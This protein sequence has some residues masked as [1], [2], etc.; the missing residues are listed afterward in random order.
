MWGERRDRKR[1]KKK[2]RRGEENRGKE[3]REERRA[4]DR[5]REGRE[6]EG[7]RG[8]KR[9]KSRGVDGGWRTGEPIPF[10]NI[11]NTYTIYLYKPFTCALTYIHTK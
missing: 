5:R 7:R 10:F 1:G 11:C 3:R 9:E 4:E 8:E 6:V 2:V